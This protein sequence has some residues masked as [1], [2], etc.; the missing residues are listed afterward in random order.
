VART[1]RSARRGQLAAFGLGFCCASA[2]GAAGAYPAF[3]RFA[4]VVADVEAHF[5]REVSASALVEAA[6][7]GLAGALDEHSAYYDA[8]TWRAIR[9]REAGLLVG[10]GVATEARACGLSVTRVEPYGPAERAGIV[11]GECIQSVDGLP[12]TA[13][14]LEGPEGTALRLGLVDGSRPRE[15]AV[16]RGRA[17]PP[18]VEARAIGNDLVHV[19]VRHLA[20]PVARPLA[21]AVAARKRAPA[22]MVLDLRGNPGGRVEEAAALVD[23]FVQSGVIVS[24]RRRAGGDDV[25]QARASADDWSFPVVVLVD[26]ET[27]SAAEI[28]AGALRDLGRAQLAGA[29]TY[30]KGSVQRLFAYEDG[31]ALKLTVGRYYLPSGTPI[32]DHQGL[33]PDVLVEPRA[34]ADA[35]LEAGIALLRR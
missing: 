11:V 25:L 35:A 16:L 23:L 33:E 30:G 2:I 6:L 26:G 17:R 32:L 34:G 22:G 12:A 3:E 28:V 21:D 31:A 4:R 8:A 27:A 13:P 24:T 5:E 18:A 1:L 19:R 7:N 15:V 14:A 10:V 20:D 29:R 9:D